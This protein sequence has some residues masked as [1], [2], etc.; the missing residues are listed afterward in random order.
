MAILAITSKLDLN[1]F[2]PTINGLN[3]DFDPAANPNYP[4]PPL[5]FS[6]ARTAGTS[7]LTVGNANSNGVFGG[8]IQDGAS[9]TLALTKIGSGTQT[10]TNANTYTGATTING[11]TLKLQYG[12]SILNS[13]KITVGAGATFDVGGVTT[14]PYA[15]GG[16]QTLGGSGATGTIAGDLSLSAGGPLALTYTAS[17]PTLTTSNLTL[18]AN[19]TTINITGGALNPGTSYTLIT[20][21]GSGTVAGT[22]G[23]ALSFTGDG[24]GGNAPDAGDKLAANW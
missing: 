13:A 5:V 16:S 4:N 12:G 17:T 3:T 14:V 22:A 21:S 2:S 11:G 9:R 6:T 15:L 24:I 23:G 1:T 19:A 18:S 8:V 20:K 10:L 7:T